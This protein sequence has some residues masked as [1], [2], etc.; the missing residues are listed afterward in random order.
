MTSPEALEPRVLFASDP[1]D[2]VDVIDNA[3]LPLIPGTTYVYRGLDSEG[4]SARSRVTVLSRTQIIDGVATT[5]V[6]DRQYV[7]N[8]LVR[9]SYR[10]YAQDT[11][12]A[13]WCFGETNR[14]VIGDVLVN[15]DDSWEAGL[16]GADPA[17]AMS[18]RRVGDEGTSKSIARVPFA[19]FADCLKT[20]DAETE[21]FHAP[22]VGL[23][24]TRESGAASTMRLAYL[25]LSP[26]AFTG[27]VDNPYFPL[28]AG[29]T[30][31]YRGVDHG[32][33]IR[34]RV[35]VMSETKQINGVP[36]TVVRDRQWEDGQLVEDTLSYYAQDKLGNVWFFG[37][38][39]RAFEDGVAVTTTSW[40]A[41]VDGARP[42]IFMRAAPST[43]DLYHI[44]KV[45]GLDEDD[46]RVLGV[47]PSPKTPLGTFSN[48]LSIE[49]S[50]TTEPNDTETKYYAPEIGLVL[51]ESDDGDET[52]RLAYVLDGQTT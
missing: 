43:G 16:D 36:A 21:N 32:A 10:F 2:F 13:V 4:R 19:T 29:T 37:E 38:Y 23:T 11:A 18:A 20:R 33:S 28:R 6:R 35:N 46:A 8:S 40:E 12:G 47:G 17:I 48:S 27:T 30:L 50:S 39:D 41:G 14:Q 9:D 51:E 22:G 44:A 3:Y 42:A 34:L 31:I 25:I 24:M 52:L 1:A 49:S 7:A 15:T 26:E 45:P 5:V